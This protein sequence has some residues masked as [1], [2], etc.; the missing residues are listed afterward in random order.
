MASEKVR[1]IINRN[2]EL[3][4]LKTPWL[5]HYQLIGEYVLTRKQNFTEQNEPGAFLTRELFDNTAIKSN[6]IMASALIGSLWP[7]GAKT[8]QIVRARNIPDSPENKRYFEDATNEMVLVMDDSRAGLTV[9][10]DE[11]M[12][13]QGAFGTSGIAIFKN[14]K[15]PLPIRYRAWDVKTMSID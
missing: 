9:A 11:Y 1:A 8:F 14:P 10:L 4:R 15:G 2:K 6:N 7:N 12:Q 3:K 13:D 5:S